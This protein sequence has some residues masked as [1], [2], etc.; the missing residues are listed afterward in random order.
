M[1]DRKSCMVIGVRKAPLT[2]TYFFTLS[3]DGVEVYR[4]AAVY[5][6]YSRAYAAA[7]KKLAA[8]EPG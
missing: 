5:L 3:H 8:L 2:P 7:E 6:S 1:K 4:S